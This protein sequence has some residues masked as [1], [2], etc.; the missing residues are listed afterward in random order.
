MIMQNLRE[1][2]KPGRLNLLFVGESAPAGGTFFYYGN[3]KLFHYT[4]TAFTNVLGCRWTSPEAFLEYFQSVGCY[5]DDLCSAP[6]NDLNPSARRIQHNQGIV[7]L[8]KRLTM[9]DD[10]PHAV[11]IVGRS[12]TKPVSKALTRAGWGDLPTSIVAFPA[13]S[14]HLRYMREVAAILE[15]AIEKGWLDL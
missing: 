6:V 13:N 2:Y 4:Q 10:R 14:H 1:L 9:W 15:S 11:I 7:P 8:G 5:L 12:I 3:S